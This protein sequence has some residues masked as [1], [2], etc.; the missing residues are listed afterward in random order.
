MKNYEI[1]EDARDNLF[2][3]N[4]K[5]KKVVDKNNKTYTNIGVSF[6]NYIW[7]E[8]NTLLFKNDNKEPYYNYKTK[9]FVERTG[10]GFNYVKMKS[11]ELSGVLDFDRL[12]EVICGGMDRKL[13]I[14]WDGGD[15]LISYNEAERLCNDFKDFLIKIYKVKGDIKYC[16]QG[17]VEDD[18]VF[19]I[20]R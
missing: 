14:D 20:K 16:I 7:N 10:C 13:F 17:S 19:F 11:N 3:D 4:L 5:R 15:S 12:F 8:P 2:R 18:F 1:Y 6:E 9:S